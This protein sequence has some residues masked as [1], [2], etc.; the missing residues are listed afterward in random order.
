MTDGIE[1]KRARGNGE[2]ESREKE[3]NV[4]ETSL[5]R[6]RTEIEYMQTSDELPSGE[7]RGGDDRQKSVCREERCR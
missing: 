5:A 3:R 4:E 1:K 7:K 2:K 6:H